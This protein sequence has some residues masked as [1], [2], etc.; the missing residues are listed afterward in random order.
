ML[1][2]KSNLGKLQLNTADLKCAREILES[3]KESKNPGPMY[4]FLIT[5]G[6]RY[7]IL[8]NGVVNGN[9]IAGEIAI[10]YLK[11]V[12]G[13][14]NQP[15]TE[16]QLINIRYDMAL[17]YLDMLQSRL[18]SRTGTIYGDINHKQA[19]KFHYIVLNKYG[20]PPE[21]WTLNP[22]LKV[23]PENF[24][25]G[26]WQ[27]TLNAAGKPAKEIWLSYYTT[28]YMFD[29]LSTSEAVDQPEIRIWLKTVSDIDNLGAVA[30]ALGNQLFTSDEAPPVSTQQCNIDISIT[31]SPLATQ[32]ITDEDQARRD[33]ANGYL[34][35]KPT[36]SLSFTDGTLDK[37]DFAS[38]QMGSMAS[39]G[40][41]PGE[42]Q[43]DPNTQPSRYLSEYYL[44]RPYYLLPETGLFDAA[45]L[46]GLSAQTTMNTYVDPL[47]LDLSGRGVKI[48]GLRDGVLFDSDNS[49]TLKRTGWAG[50]DTGMLV[51]DNGSGKIENISQM[52]SEY[53]AGATGVEGQP[54]ERRYQDGF[55]ALASEDS[56][57][58][59]V[60][61]KGDP[62]WHKLRVWYDSSGNGIV[63]RGELRTLHHWRISQ[64]NVD[65][66][67]IDNDIRNGN[68]VMARS[69]FMMNGKPREVL[70]VNFISSP[71]SNTITKRD[72]NGA[73]IRSVIGDVTTTAY[74]QLSNK[75]AKLFA[76]VLAVNNI[77]GGNKDDIL[78]ASA[79][80][81][82]LV[83]RGGSN[84]YKGKSGN[85]VFV[86]SASDDPNNIQGNGGTDTVLI[87]GDKAVALNMAHSGITIAQGG[88][89]DDIILSGGDSGVFIKGGKGNSTLVGGGG[90]DVLSGGGGKNRIVG[91]S[92]KAVIYAGS[93]GDI[94]Y[95]SEQGSI[96]HA[97]GGT[98]R[99]YGNKSDDVIVAGKG[100]AL[101][102]GGGG[103]NVVALHGSY[104]D[105]TMT[106]TKGGYQVKDKVADR[107][108]TLTLKNIQKLNFADIS[109]VALGE[110]RIIPLNDIL[111]Y[112]DGSPISRFLDT[113]IPAQAVLGNDFRFNNET[114]LVIANV[115]DAIGGTV[116]LKDDG[117]VLF[118]PDSTFTGVMSFKYEVKS[119]TG[120]PALFVMN[121]PSGESTTMRATVVMRSADIP[122]DPLLIKQTY[123]NDINV[124]PVW[125][126][127]TGKGVRIGQFEPG[128]QF[129]T[130]PEIFDIQHPDLV[131]N[132]DPHWLATQQN[133]GVLPEA[134]SNHA[135]MVAGVMVAAKNQ[136]GGVGVAYD[137]TLGGHYLSNNGAD[138]TTLGKM[139]SYDVVNH[140][141]GFKHEFAISNVSSGMINLANILNT[142]LHY[143]AANGRGGLG[144]IIVTS[145]G[146]Q[147]EQG[148]STQG[149]LMSNSR[150]GIQ[151][152][153]MNAKAD[154]STLRA[155]SEPFSNT[156][157]SLL[158]SAPGSHILSSSHQITTERGAVFGAQ[159]SHE[160]GT[161]FAAPI[162]SGIA[163]LMLQANP[164]L[165]FRDVQ[166]IL[167]LSA[168][169]V[170]DTA[171]QW[172]INRAKNWNGGG[173][174]VSHDYGFGVVDAR[175]AVRLAESWTV[176]KTNAN[177]QVLEARHRFGARGPLSAGMARETS[178]VLSDNLDFDIEQVEVDFSANVGRL[179][180]L[181][182]TLISPNGT[183]SIL[184]DRAGK[185]TTDSDDH[186]DVDVDTGSQI[187]GDFNHTFMSTHHRGEQSG[188][189]WRLMV[190]NS[191]N[192][193]P[194]ELKKW[195]LRLFGSQ[196]SHDDTYFYTDEFTALVAQLPARAI[197]D[198]VID[199]VAGGRNTLNA[200]AM[201]GDV[202]VNLLT[203][204]A[205]LGGTPLTIRSPEHI[206]NLM[207]GD[208]NDTLTAGKQHSVLDGGR[209][210]NLL[211]GG[212]GK[213]IFVVRQRANGSDWIV[214]FDADKGELIQLV[215]FA[216]QRFDTVQLIQAEKDVKVQLADNQHIIIKDRQVTALKAHHFHFEDT[217][218]PP[219]GYF[220]SRMRIEGPKA[221]PIVLDT[222]AAA[223][224]SGI[225]LNGG[226]GGVSLSFVDNKMVAALSGKVYQ[227]DNAK[228]SIYVVMSQQGKLEYGNAVRGFRAG[229][230]KIDLSAVGIRN[231]SELTLT[232]RRS[233]VING[234]ALIQGVDI[235][236]A[237]QGPEGH[238]IELAYL[239][240][241]DVEHL[242]AKDFIFAEADAMLSDSPFTHDDMGQLINITADFDRSIRDYESVF[243]PAKT[244]QLVAP[245]L[246]AGPC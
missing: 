220:D 49:G 45:T 113:N 197:L 32:R 99:I 145:G 67:A 154:L 108:G 155:H 23:M 148:G 24:R 59:G 2:K 221:A 207:G 163:A 46:N 48:S 60:I 53:Y 97:G 160:Q 79:A 20:L 124:I 95:A 106:R 236:S 234:L 88:D 43:L 98:D 226:G 26:Y 206:H 167:A 208:G 185:K 128:G 31:P 81:S 146:N 64:I 166:T 22:V 231:F 245:T 58:N 211:E 179:G 132:V 171:T 18:D 164:N 168:R 87:T 120:D 205:S 37:T 201:S 5:K 3:H 119:T 77:Y 116:Q 213:E 204:K 228:P 216:D 133:T 107:D 142:T 241:L 126:D 178:I 9:S 222:S 170:D 175:A 157:A 86:I 127:Y 36:H 39:G 184:L 209:G 188:G 82:W 238:S 40:I 232:K 156:G 52:Y 100:D 130:V 55:A 63:D 122:N 225:M 17:G 56:D 134:I 16:V 230:D 153:A 189:Q 125:Q 176:Q 235:K 187:S 194:V 135:S 224:P 177:Q 28:K 151:V 15:I 196:I 233:M 140:S 91:G 174:H 138:L 112:G 218:A 78:T 93:Q 66:S 110:N 186:G 11:S 92:G 51:I 19:E 227:R 158:I 54:G 57:G 203:G 80:G 195:S 14:H 114:K 44:E 104:A 10:S 131:A 139:S 192:G 162:V 165:G 202:K 65:A 129:A 136:V 152:G 62:V 141:W 83:G 89:G 109:A 212:V 219:A 47:L 94:I 210:I 121:L 239:D 181:T 242:D 6:D 96:I 42:I 90:N 144:T 72:N 33:V 111:I 69:I 61:D 76:D 149:S 35:N 7:A 115:S 191:Q 229:I 105:Y 27:D 190:R 70:A 73:F 13:G 30:S 173:M 240:G 243:V 102:D 169:R 217:F 193:L 34:V 101:I 50:P 172:R 198:D 75:K 117:D 183:K 246:T 159:Y 137:A 21:A 38:V 25:E 123:L 1:E 223:K 180:D 118:M 103:I 182:L 41:R 215:G 29:K 4:D 84:T 147:R 237:A 161:S 68:R 199:G 71:V 200:A 214:N 74:V 244:A 8:A 12:A 143:A 150:F 85:D